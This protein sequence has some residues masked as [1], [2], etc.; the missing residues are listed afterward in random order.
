MGLSIKQN[1]TNDAIRQPAERMI[2]I[3][4]IQFLN[5]ICDR[6]KFSKTRLI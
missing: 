5:F 3:N 2:R 1:D 4:T 6:T